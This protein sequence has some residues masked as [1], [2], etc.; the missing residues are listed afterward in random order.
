MAK[1][2]PS[3]KKPAKKVGKKKAAAKKASKKKP[4]KKSPP[5]NIAAIALK[6]PEDPGPDAS[7]D[8]IKTYQAETKLFRIRQKHMTILEV[9]AEKKRGTDERKDKIGNLREAMLSVIREEAHDKPG[10]E[11]DRCRTWQLEIDKLEIALAAFIKAKSERLKALDAEFYD[12][13]FDEQLTL[14]GTQAASA[15]AKDKPKGGKP[16]HGARAPRLPPAAAPA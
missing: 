10:R 7:P 12:L 1:R 14:P 6:P 11:L 8:V 2:N 13:V 15:P 9:Q 3:K 4:S 16:P 5:K